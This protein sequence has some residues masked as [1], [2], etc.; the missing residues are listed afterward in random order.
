MSE[1]MTPA[2]VLEWLAGLEVDCSDC[3]GKGWRRY[4]SMVEGMVA[5]GSAEDCPSCQRGK[6]PR[7]PTLRRVCPR[8]DEHRYMLGMPEG[9]GQP[10]GAICSC[11]QGR[12][13][14]VVDSL[15]ATLEAARQID[16]VQLVG[17]G[18]GYSATLGTPD[19]RIGWTDWCK[20]PNEAALCALAKMVAEE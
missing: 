9:G 4:T 1:P 16:I 8:S 6:V 3:H 20:T 12:G 5:V 18:G 7:F 15:E 17:T 2:E 11:C 19:F 14:A 10:D 13:Y